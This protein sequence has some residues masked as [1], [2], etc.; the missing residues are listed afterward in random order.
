MPRGIKRNFTG[1][2]VVQSIVSRDDLAKYATSCAYMRNFIAQV[3]GSA[4]FRPG[5]Q[6]VG[7]SLGGDTVM[8]PFEFNTEQ[9][10]QYILVLTDRKLQI[11]Q[12]SG[13][14]VDGLDARI[15]VTTPYLAT[16]LEQVRAAQNGDTIY[17]VHR[18]HPIQKLSRF[19]HTSW[20][21]AP[22]SFDP[23]IAPPVGGMSGTM[24]GTTGS[25]EQRYVITSVDVDGRE[26]IGSNHIA[27]T[28]CRPSSAWEQ[29]N[30]V[31]LQWS[32]VAGA[33]QYNI[34][35]DA[36]GR[37]A[38]IGVT[39]TLNYEDHN[40]VGDVEVTPPLANNPFVSGN[41]PGAVCFH[42]QRLVLGGTNS[43][44]STFYQSRTG[45]F[46]NFTK[47]NPTKDDDMLE[48]T[49]ASGK[50]DQIKWVAPF[51]DLMVGTAGSE[52]RVTGRDGGG[53][54]TP[55]SVDAKPQSYWGS[56]EVPPIVIGNSI[57]HVRR[58]GGAVRDLFYSL[59]K[60]GYAGNDLSILATHLFDGHSIRSWS[61]QQTPDSIIWC[62]RDDGVLLGMTYLK[63]HEIWGWHV[64]T[65]QGE[66]EAVCTIDGP[67]ED[68]TYVVVKRVI[69]GQTLR[70][71]ELIT[72]KWRES[73][74]IENA[75]FVDAGLQYNGTP[76]T[77]LLN[78]DHLEGETVS[79]LADGSVYTSRVVTG[80]QITLDNPASTVIVGLPYSGVLTPL[81]FEAEGPEGTT[82]G[83]LRGFGKITLRLKDSRGGKVGTGSVFDHPDDILYEPLEYLQEN[84]DE[85]V[86]P[87]TGVKE[88]HP[89]TDISVEETIF[90]K[91][92]SPLPFNVMSI[93]AEVDIA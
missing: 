37:Y 82:Q 3:H 14:V 33:S 41:Y 69:N 89:A 18:N 7:E 51:A 13:F 59:E 62:V 75:F 23:V 61:Y 54:I 50:V 80:G 5:T 35:K 30:Y 15:T 79:V 81:P 91:Q 11:V 32:A 4:M 12:D 73:D 25:F 39:S 6:F 85:P 56:G 20:T 78:L 17:L 34:Y 24:Y 57:L 21:L 26:S 2:E 8:L 58:Q 93:V 63:E 66:F 31:R 42:Q 1:G 74:G 22:V 16:E 88:I 53:T 9:E 67:K 27:V 44:P 71:V 10:D 70:W 76:V 47:S 64:H 55:V 49:L 84:W 60:D 40:Y 68:R 29:G 45:D 38:F 19:S 52:I 90:I 87:Y 83:K 65:T 48:F 46:E 77:T 92:D 43:K 28:N 86:Q 36:Q 72:P